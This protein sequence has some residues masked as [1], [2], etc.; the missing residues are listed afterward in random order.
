VELEGE[1]GD[2]AGMIWQY[3]NEHGQTILD[4]LRQG[5][6]LSDQLL[7]VGVGWLGR[8]GKVSIVQAGSHGEGLVA[9]RL[10]DICD[11]R[12]RAGPGISGTGSG[13]TRGRRISYAQV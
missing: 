13:A 8:E 10:S 6:K 5:T 12:E 11:L 4:R 3:L 1:I 7:L 9:R 2:A